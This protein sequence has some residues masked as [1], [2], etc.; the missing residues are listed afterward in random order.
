MG[1]LLVCCEHWVCELQ[2]K[3]QIMMQ[4]CVPLSNTAMEVEIVQRPHDAKVRTSEVGQ[5]NRI[6]N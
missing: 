5:I 2:L 4:K 1:V 6:P 3:M